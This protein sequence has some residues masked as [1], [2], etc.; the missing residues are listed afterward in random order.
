V[1][2]LVLTFEWSY[3][4][5]GTNAIIPNYVT[6]SHLVHLISSIFKCTTQFFAFR[7]RQFAPVTNINW[8][9]WILITIQVIH[10]YN[11][12]RI[13]WL[14]K[15]STTVPSVTISV[16]DRHCN[17]DSKPFILREQLKPSIRTKH[18]CWE[19]IFQKHAAI[20]T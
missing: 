5:H 20:P 11:T 4:V 3:Y 19:N 1:H 6:F 8:K 12:S 17:T 9:I 15:L 14:H 13:N 10:L 7:H 18:S 16:K 2:V